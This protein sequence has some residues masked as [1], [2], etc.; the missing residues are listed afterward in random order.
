MPKLHCLIGLLCA[1]CAPSVALH[2]ASSPLVCASDQEAR[3]TDTRYDC[4]SDED[5][6]STCAYGAVHRRWAPYL[7]SACQDG[8]A[9]K[10]MQARCV[11]NRCASFDSKG[12]RDDR[13]SS[14]PAPAQVCVDS[15]R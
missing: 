7:Q 3:S 4:T 6:V 15:E 1:A 2:T 13:C 8:C 10:G 14:R 5:C 11:E 9:S 12:V